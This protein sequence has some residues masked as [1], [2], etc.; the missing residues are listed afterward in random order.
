MAPTSLKFHGS[1]DSKYASKKPKM[2]AN[3]NHLKP[4]KREWYSLSND[5]RLRGGSIVSLLVCVKV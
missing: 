4:Y 3:D 2:V 5:L 1:Y